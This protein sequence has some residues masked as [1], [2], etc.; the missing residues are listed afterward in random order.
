MLMFY[1]RN[2]TGVERSVKADI[3]LGLS[4]AFI[5]GAMNAGG[6][7]AVQQ[8]TS[9]MT[10]IVSSMA[11]GLAIGNFNLVL[12]SVGA[13]VCFMVGAGLTEVWSIG[14]VEN[15]FRVNMPCR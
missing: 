9:H 2:L 15:G 4:L 8:Y 5:A 11:D 6:F 14:R 13:M 12:A 10:G 1:L 7:L 3:H